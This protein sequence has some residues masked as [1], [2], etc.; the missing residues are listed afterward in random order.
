MV[1][2][3]LQQA[4]HSGYLRSISS[5]GALRGELRTQEIGENQKGDLRVR[6]RELV[7]SRWGLIDTNCTNY[8]LFHN[9]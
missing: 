7:T 1:L 3:A 8:E 4:M 9:N 2:G 5:L 6:T